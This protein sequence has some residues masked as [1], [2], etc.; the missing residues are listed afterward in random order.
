LRG[1]V[2]REGVGTEGRN[3]PSSIVCT[4]EYLK[5]KGL[6]EWCKGSEFKLQYYKKTQ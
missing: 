1:W 2:V 6:V 3:D 5:T 4:Y